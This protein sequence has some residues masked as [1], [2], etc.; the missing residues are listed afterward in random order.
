MM[1][2]FKTKKEISKKIESLKSERNSIGFVPTMG[3]LHKG[4]LS[5]IECSANKNDKTVVSIFINPA[6]F[7]DKKD[8]ENYPRSL[9]SDL[10]LLRESKCDIIF[11]PSVNEMYPE[12][13]NR[14]FNFGNLDKIMEGKYRPGHFDGVAKII[15]RLFEVISPHKAYF[16]LKDFQQLAII[17]KL[18]KDLKFA[19]Q[20][21]SCPTVRESDGLAMSSRNSLL[22]PEQRK[23]AAQIYHTLCQANINAAEND[24]DNIKEQ[25][26]T[27]LNKIPFTEVEYFEIVDE[28]DLH[29]AENWDNKS[30]KV[31]CIAVRIGKV[32]LIDN[33]HFNL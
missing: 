32:R 7:N 14:K 33:I 9:D 5:L 1:E 22:S 19:I 25:V 27:T 4:H 3:T 31:G 10:R 21:I 26:I 13:D 8:L 30:G 24:I 11:T 18:T 29:P 15:V 6:Q 2:I 17:K 12:P 20:I 23:H 28:I 16:G